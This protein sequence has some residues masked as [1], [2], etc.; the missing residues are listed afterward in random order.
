MQLS[1]P[2]TLLSARCTFFQCCLFVASSHLPICAEGLTNVRTSPSNCTSVRITTL[3]SARLST[4]SPPVARTH[5]SRNG[6]SLSKGILLAPSI[7]NPQR[8]AS[9][10]LNLTPEYPIGNTSYQ[11]SESLEQCFPLLNRCVD[12]LVM[13]I[14]TI[15]QLFLLYTTLKLRNGIAVN[16]NYGLGDNTVGAKGQRL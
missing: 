11:R 6:K 8:L 16:V 10:S 9:Y 12:S 2:E 5:S 3:S 13:Y 4:L 15:G 14:Q 7:C 1:C